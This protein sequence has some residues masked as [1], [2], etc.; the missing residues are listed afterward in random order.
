MYIGFAMKHLCLFGFQELSEKSKF[1][2]CN[3]DLDVDTNAI[4]KLKTDNWYDMNTA[5]MWF[6]KQKPQALTSSQLRVFLALH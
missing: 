5:L 1:P 4:Y 6:F 2:G 3:Q